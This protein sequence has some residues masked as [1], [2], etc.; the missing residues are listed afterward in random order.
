MYISSPQDSRI[1][2]QCKNHLHC[3]NRRNPVSELVLSCLMVEYMHSDP[4]SH[5]ATDTGKPKKSLLA[6][7]PLVILRFPFVLAKCQECNDINNTKINDKIFVH[8]FYKKTK[9]QNSAPF[10][11]RNSYLFLLFYHIFRNLFK[12]DFTISWLIYFTTLSNNS[13]SQMYYT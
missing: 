12:Q 4:C 11:S 3:K 2:N 10:T 9:F 13:P 1:S 5:R 6:G 7:S 8:V